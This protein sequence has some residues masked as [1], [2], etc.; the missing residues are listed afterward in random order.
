GY[1]VSGNGPWPR[2]PSQGS[3]RNLQGLSQRRSMGE[4]PGGRESTL[5]HSSRQGNSAILDGKVKACIRNDHWADIRWHRL[6][7]FVSRGLISRISRTKVQQFPQG[8][9]SSW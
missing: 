6:S 4:V 1:S 5:Y 8:P 3:R 9:H 2:D 7:R